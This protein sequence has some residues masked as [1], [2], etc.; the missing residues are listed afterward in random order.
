MYFFSIFLLSYSHEKQN[1]SIS[2]YQENYTSFLNAEMKVHD[3]KI[4]LHETPVMLQKY[5]A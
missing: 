5:C 1:E 4:H 2:K 3:L